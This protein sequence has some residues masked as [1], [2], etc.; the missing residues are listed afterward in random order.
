[1]TDKIDPKLFFHATP[2]REKCSDGG[3][4]DFVGWREWSIPGQGGGG[5]TACARCGIG[6][7]EHSLRYSE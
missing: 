7:M 6:A 2:N 5:E 4:H 1:M 3:E